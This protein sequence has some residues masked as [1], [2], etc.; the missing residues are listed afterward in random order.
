VGFDAIHL[1]RYF[2]YILLAVP[3]LCLSGGGSSTHILPPSFMLLYYIPQAP[4]LGSH[5][6]A[7]ST[8]YHNC[9]FC[10]DVMLRHTVLKMSYKT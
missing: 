9:F 6:L 10:C 7:E 1:L 8:F 2:E 3:V 5:L 4:V